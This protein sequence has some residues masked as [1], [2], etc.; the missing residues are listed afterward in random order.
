VLARTVGRGAGR[1]TGA[2]ESRNGE[3]DPTRPA[4]GGISGKAA[5]RR[6]GEATG[7]ARPGAGAAPARSVARASWTVANRDPRPRWPPA[8]AVGGVPRAANG[9]R[10]DGPASRQARP[11][12]VPPALWRVEAVADPTMNILAWPG[13]AWPLPRRAK[14]MSSVATMHSST[15]HVG[16]AARP[17]WRPDGAEGVCGQ[18]VGRLEVNA[19]R[20]GA[21]PLGVG[22]PGMAARCGRRL[23]RPAAAP[24]A[25]SLRWSETRSGWRPLEAVEPE[26]LHHPRPEVLHHH[27]REAHE[28]LDDLPRP[29]VAEVEGQAQLPRV[30]A[31]EVGALV[32]AAGLELLRRLT[33]VVA[34]AGSL[35][36]DHASPQ[37]GQEPRAVGPGQDAREVQHAHAVE[38]AGGGGAHGCRHSPHPAPRCQP[39]RPDTRAARCRASRKPGP[40]VPL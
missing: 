15:R 37:V 40:G 24:S 29:G 28:I 23:A 27:V 34:A 22:D 7:R 11:E 39:A 30:E 36:L 26:P 20:R 10:P 2:L 32:G 12:L 5:P 38:G 6:W 33:D 18:H 1:L 17:R 13:R 14:A 21:V 31:D 4:P 16:S 9:G 35:D 3:A 19:G 8:H 25:R